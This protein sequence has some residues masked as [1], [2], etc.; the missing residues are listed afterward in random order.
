MELGERVCDRLP[1]GLCDGNNA[2][3]L[4]DPFLQL[5]SRQSA[6]WRLAPDQ[7]TPPSEVDSSAVNFVF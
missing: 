1:K 4:H 3:T 7:L 6:F 5:S 2:A